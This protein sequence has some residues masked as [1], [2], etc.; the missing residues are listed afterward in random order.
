MF[1]NTNE[2]L[3]KIRLGEDSF[4]EFKEVEIRGQR[5]AN[6]NAESMAG[7]CTA[8]ANSYGGVILL[9]VKDSGEIAGIPP[10]H[11]AIA[12]QWIENICQN[13]CDPPL[14]PILTKIS[15]PSVSGAQVP[16]IKVEIPRSIFAHATS[17]GLWYH[18][19]GSSKQKLSPQALARLFQQRGQGYAF[20]EKTILQANYEDL[21]LELYRKYHELRQLGPIDEALVPLSHIFVNLKIAAWDGDKIVPTVVGMLMFGK[22][23][24]QY[25]PNAAIDC[26]IYSGTQP[27]SNW[28]VN[29]SQCAGTVG[30]QIVR[31]MEFVKRYIEMPA[32]KGEEGRQDLMQYSL[33]AVHEA[34][35]NAV[36]HRDYS[37]AGS[38]IRLFM[39]DD[40]LEL[41][42]PGRLPNTVSIA[43]LYAGAVPYR[44]NQLLVGFLKEHVS[45]ITL[46]AFMESR[47][48][49]V[50]LIIRESEKISGRRPLYEE[51]GEAVKLTIYGRENPNRQAKNERRLTGNQ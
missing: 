28:L 1:D 20:E 41:T 49:G 33:R 15:L 27:D 10:E 12:Q 26:A 23:P 19:V 44:R 29:A 16:V 11:L 24:Q 7:E 21:D 50:L 45:P 2:L 3:D 30:E 14:T 9:G 42:S 32:H 34:I 6:P 13:N 22:N 46:R 5:V 37:I 18:R 51:V 35:V 17:G 25:L 38:S 31:A 4:L 47:G 40:R 39:F 48:E 43:S 8:F 36:A